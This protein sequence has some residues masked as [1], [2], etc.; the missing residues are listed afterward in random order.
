ML[1]ADTD[2]VVNPVNTTG[3][4]GKEIARTFKQT[5][6]ENFAEY[7]AACRT[8]QVILG[9]ML[10][11]E[12]RTLHGP[13][14]IIHFPTSQGSRQS[15][16]LE[17]IVEGLVDLRRVIKEQ[18]IQSIAV[19]PLGCGSGGLDWN[20]VRSVITEGLGDMPTVRVVVYE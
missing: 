19:P 8:K 6:P 15:S 10:L 18:G 14:W 20:E 7:E 17:W 12:N 1:L 3:V 4:V 11:T 13:R 5:Y 16:R 2:A 9:R